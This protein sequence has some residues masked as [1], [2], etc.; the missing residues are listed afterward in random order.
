MKLNDILKQYK[1][2]EEAKAIVI[3]SSGANKTSDKLSDIDVYVFVEKNIPVSD[4]ENIIKQKFFKIWS[5]RRV[6]WFRWWIFCWW[7]K[8]TIEVYVIAEYGQLLSESAKETEYFN[9][10]PKYVQEKLT[11]DL[12]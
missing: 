10:L 7:I 1:D 8:S 3:G 6:F 5:R 9:N 4:R 2:F 12:K 11:V